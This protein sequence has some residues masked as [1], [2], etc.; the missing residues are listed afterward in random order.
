MFST[1]RLIAYAQICVKYAKF[2]KKLCNRCT[3]S[4]V[5]M[6]QP[7]IVGV[8]LLIYFSLL[9]PSCMKREPHPRTDDC[10]VVSGTPSHRIVCSK[11]FLLFLLPSKKLRFRSCLLS[12][13]VNRSPDT[14]RHRTSTARAALAHC[15]A[16]PFRPHRATGHSSAAR[17][18][19]GAREC[20]QQWPIE[21]RA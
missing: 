8:F 20:G 14:C 15:A 16:F 21:H 11:A 1:Q 4:V 6:G 19:R 9:D 13:S 17:S 12:P 5:T 7:S 18:Q 2:V 3:P 10:K